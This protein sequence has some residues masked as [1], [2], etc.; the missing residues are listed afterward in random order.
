MTWES[1]VLVA[2][3]LLFGGALYIRLRWRHAP[4]AFRA[5]IVLATCYFFAGS[6][7]GAWVLHIAAPKL[8]V[9]VIEVAPPGTRM[10]SPTL[11]PP[12]T[13]SAPTAGPYALL[14]PFH[15]DL[16]HA[17]RPNPKL[18]P[19]DVFPDATKDDICTP[20]W[21]R[22][23]RHVTESERYQAYAEYGRTVGPGCCEVDHLIP[24]ELGGSNDIKNLWPQPDDPRP[25]TGEKD[26]LEN[27]LHRLVCAGKIPLVEAQH[28]IAADWVS[29]WKK[30]EVSP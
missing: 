19:G 30:Y 15:Y 28:C 11:A 2:V 29:C 10:P 7:I 21:S 22:D 5:M 20:G 26:Q 9:P 16:T 17:I 13:P 18:T 23:H 8:E 4:Q 14:P 27:T 12:M 3:A 1:A 6:V 24:L 25:G